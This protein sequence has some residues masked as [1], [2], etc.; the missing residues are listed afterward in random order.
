MFIAGFFVR[1]N[2]VIIPGV[3]RRKL[4]SK[5]AATE[6]NSPIFLVKNPVKCRICLTNLSSST[7]LN[8]AV[9]FIKLHKQTL[10]SVSMWRVKGICV[11][12]GS[13]FANCKS[14]YLQK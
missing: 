11:K 5:Q 10:I 6:A 2:V 14:N 3:N 12:T 13:K 9:M 4:L 1:L 7:I 8:C